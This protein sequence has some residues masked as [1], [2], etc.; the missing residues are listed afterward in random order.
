M[1]E[2]KLPDVGEG[3]TEGEIL[4]WMVKPGDTVTAA[5]SGREAGA[6]KVFRIENEDVLDLDARPGTLIYV[7]QE[8]KMGMFQPRNE[9]QLV[10]EATGRAGVLES[11][12]T[13]PQGGYLDRGMLYTGD[14]IGT[15]ETADCVTEALPGGLI[16]QQDMVA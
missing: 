14:S 6:H 1:A 7:W 10:D 5:P 4:Q 16:L 3:L 13:D 2:F 11:Q 12:G 8:V 15:H 9:L